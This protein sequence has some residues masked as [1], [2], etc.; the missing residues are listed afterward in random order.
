MARCEGYYEGDILSTEWVHAGEQGRLCTQWNIDYC[1]V[2]G[3]YMN[4]ILAVVTDSYG[5]QADIKL[6][7][8]GFE[9]K[10]GK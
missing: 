2:D 9:S 4:G 3:G 1:I 8:E 10:V 5:D 6:N 7:E